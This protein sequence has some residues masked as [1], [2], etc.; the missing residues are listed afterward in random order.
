MPSYLLDTNAVPDTIREHTGIKAKI[1]AQPSGELL[2]S[3]VVV[4]EIRYGFERLA[5]GRRRQHLEIKAWRVLDAFRSVVVTEAAANIYGR[6]KRTLE[7]QD[8]SLN[9]NDLWIA[10]TVLSLPAVLV[11]RDTDFARVPGLQVEDWTK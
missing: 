5:A 7:T 9:D 10:A 1:A 3:V 4:G 8:L 6:M 11:S 2:T